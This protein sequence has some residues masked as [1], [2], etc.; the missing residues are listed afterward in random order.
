VC[1]NP[2]TR[3]FWL[4]RISIFISSY[5]IVCTVNRHGSCQRI[6]FLAFDA[7]CVS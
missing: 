3:W 4:Y 7:H 6:I 5:L 2:S 1:G